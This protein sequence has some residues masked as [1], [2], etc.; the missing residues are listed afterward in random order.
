M[1]IF[2]NLFLDKIKPTAELH[3]EIT[4]KNI[5]KTIEKGDVSNV[6]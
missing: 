2:P 3:I 5:T 6:N 4:S 1:G